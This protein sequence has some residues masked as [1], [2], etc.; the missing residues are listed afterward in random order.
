MMNK[1]NLLLDFGILAGFLLA[2]E[3]FLTGIALHEWLSIGFAALIVIHLLLH[4]KWITGVGVAFFKK[5][6]HSS[7]LKFVVDTL[8]FISFIT[9]MLSGLM[10]SKVALPALGINLGEG[11]A[12]RQLHSLSANT[13]LALVGLHFALSWNWVVNMTWRYLLLPVVNL[14]KSRR[15]AVSSK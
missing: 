4:W 8:L 10:I 14:F 3:P 6:F 12:W 1:T 15:V 11:G 2:I 13:T 5:L 7:R 9:I